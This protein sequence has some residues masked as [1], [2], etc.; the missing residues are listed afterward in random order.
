MPLAGKRTRIAAGVESGGEFQE[1]RRQK[2]DAAVRNRTLPPRI[3]VVEDQDDVRRLLM[4]ALNLEGYVVAEAANA[5]QAL[6]QLGRKPYDLVITDYAMPGATGAW[7]L[8]EAG[9][10]GL[11]QRTAAMIVTA[12]AEEP[13]LA[14]FAV[15]AKPVDLDDFLE[16]VRNLLAFGPPVTADGYRA[17]RAK[18][19]PMD[20]S[21]PDSSVRSRAKQKRM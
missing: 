16:T 2:A 7:M 5:T 17:L 15:L 1:S 14:E 8:A 4:T 3:L 21:A 9:R 13:D 12:H 10:R 20:A 19:A 11:M 18:T 6:S